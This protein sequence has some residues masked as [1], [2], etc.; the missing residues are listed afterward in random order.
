MRIAT[1]YDNE[2]GNIGQHFGHAQHIKL[3]DISPD[4]VVSTVIIPTAGSGHEA[5]SQLMHQCRADTL[6]CGGIGG[7]ARAALLE[8]GI[9]TIAGVVG[10]ADDAVIA[11]LEN[12]L[13][14]ITNAPTCDH[15]HGE[16]HECG[17]GCD[18]SSCGCDCDCIG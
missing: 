11:F 12:R 3:Y 7:P 2:T 5:M 13:D 17:G 1:T 6:I 8:E 9:V 14:G 18:C 15:H 16:G 4:G 10:K